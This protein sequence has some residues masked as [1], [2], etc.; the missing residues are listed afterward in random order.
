MLSRQSRQS[1]QSRMSHY[2][3]DRIALAHNFGPPEVAVTSDER[4]NYVGFALSEPS[5]L[6]GA[7][8]LS[9]TGTLSRVAALSSVRA[10]T[11]EGEGQRPR[12]LASLGNAEL[13]GFRPK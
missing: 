12:C 13:S 10:L 4:W 1:Y 6:S 3:G 7:L 8:P 5:T 9:P 11:H 2:L